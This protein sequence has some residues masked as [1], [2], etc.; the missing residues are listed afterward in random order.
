MPTQCQ[1]QIDSVPRSR[2][3][4]LNRMKFDTLVLRTNFVLY[5]ACSC[6]EMFENVRYYS[7]AV[8]SC[9]IRVY[10]V[11][12]VSLLPKFSHTDDIM[13][14]NFGKD[15]SFPSENGTFE[16]RKLHGRYLNQFFWKNWVRITLKFISI[17][18]SEPKVVLYTVKTTS[19]ATNFYFFSRP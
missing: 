5:M 19:C 10:C 6:V 4:I 18:K 1:S 17:I 12:F 14:R 8:F 15:W 13:R 2:A 9:D 7:P 3:I 16:I 11:E